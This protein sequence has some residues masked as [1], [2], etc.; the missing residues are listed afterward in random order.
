MNLL[1][2]CKATHKNRVD[3]GVLTVRFCGKTTFVAV[4]ISALD[5]LHRLG[6]RCYDK[7]CEFQLWAVLYDQIPVNDVTASKTSY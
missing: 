5:F 6:A 1:S 2:L 7:R 4:H 3:I